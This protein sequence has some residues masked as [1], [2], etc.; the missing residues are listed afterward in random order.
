[1]QSNAIESLSNV[2]VLCL[3]KTGTLTANRLQLHALHPLGVPEAEL[4]RIL[5]DCA[6]S[7]AAGNRTTEA[8]GAALPGQP[9][10]VLA[11][12]PFSSERKWSGLAID[13]GVYVLGAP[14][15]LRPHVRDGVDL[16]TQAE[17]WATAGLRVLLVA[18][19]PPGSALHDADGQPTLPVELQP[20]GLIGV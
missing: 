11:E 15:V 1:Q 14:E 4:R 16:E 7:T 5:G 3:D 12:A 10:P 17:A 20:L 6:A 8:L 19:A 13:E 18:A 2:D 9:R